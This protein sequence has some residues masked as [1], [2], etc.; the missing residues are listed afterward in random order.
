[1]RLHSLKRSLQTLGGP[2]IKRFDLTLSLTCITV[3]GMTKKPSESKS[4]AGFNSR[5]Q[6]AKEFS[7]IP[8]D[9]GPTIASILLLEMLADQMGRLPPSFPGSWANHIRSKKTVKR[10]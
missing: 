8:A 5:G 6:F 3:A 7:V 2:T 10:D 9:A 4:S 1:M